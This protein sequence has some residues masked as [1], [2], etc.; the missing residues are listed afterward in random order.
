MR[1]LAAG[2]AGVT[3][4]I[5]CIAGETCMPALGEVIPFDHREPIQ[6]RVLD[7]KSGQPI[8]HVRLIFTAGYTDGDLRRRLWR[9]ESATDLRGQAQLPRPLA[10]FPFLRI[11]LHGAGQCPGQGETP[12]NVARIRS[13]GMSAPNRCGFIGTEEAAGTLTLFARSSNSSDPRP[14]Q[15]APARP[16]PAEEQVNFLPRAE[17]KESSASA[18]NELQG[19]LEPRPENAAQFIGS[20][21]LSDAGTADPG[22]VPLSDAYDEMCLRQR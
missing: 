6:I 10:N 17:A 16:A 7:G 21:G 8:P 14:A 3:W 1:K 5:T 4:G 19:L 20:T 9:E 2:I 13:E 22:T 18:G 15:A 12:Y 11:T